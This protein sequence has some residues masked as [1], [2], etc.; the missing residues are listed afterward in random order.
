MT[1]ARAAAPRS[2]RA[3]LLAAACAAL[4]C[5]GFIALGAWQ[6]QRL[7]WKNTLVAQV[8]QRVHAA[9]AAAPP[10]AA[11][12]RLSKDADEYRHLRLS[13]HFLDQSSTRVQASTVLGPGFWLLTPLRTD[14][15][16]IVIVNRG[17]IAADARPA[18]AGADRVTVT[19]LLRMSERGGGFLRDNDP[20][21]NRWYSRDVAAIA[22]ARG[23]AP[24]A[25][26]FLD[27]DAKKTGTDPFL[28]D[29]APASTGG[30]NGPGAISPV[31]ETPPT[32]RI[33]NGSDP[34]MLEG[35]AGVEPAGGLTVISFHNNHLVY[36]LTWFAM[37]LL[38]AGAV[39]MV[40]REK[41]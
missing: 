3:R 20:L 35:T 11:W 5:L 12:P 7:H 38:A 41:D 4:L 19:G 17:F 14:D 34:K 37:A 36:A 32:A 21:H 33:K 6:V 23:L 15:G 26:Y 13:G 1:E 24:V 40:M 22:A 10:P 27:Q 16:A 29:A 39:Y 2:T 18:G 8:D 31:N 25:P 9:P 30:K 28:M